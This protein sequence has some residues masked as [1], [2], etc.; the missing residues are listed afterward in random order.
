MYEM[1]LFWLIC[2]R[3][4]FA[5]NKTTAPDI[6]RISLEFG[7][8]VCRMEVPAKLLFDGAVPDIRK[9]QKALEIQKRT[10]RYSN[11][12]GE[13]ET[14][15]CAFVQLHKNSGGT[16]YFSLHIH[17]MLWY[18]LL[19]FSKGYRLVN[20]YSMLGLKSSASAAMYIVVGN[21]TKSITYDIDRLRKLL[22]CD[23]PG[24]NR[25][26]NFTKVLERAREELEQWCTT[27]F[28]YNARRIGKRIARIEIIPHS[29][30]PSRSI[31]DDV[32]NIANSISTGVDVGVMEYAR[33][34]FNL[35]PN[36]TKT[37]GAYLRHFKN[38]EEAMQLLSDI[39]HTM[40]KGHPEGISN[41]G[42]YLISALKQACNRLM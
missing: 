3:A 1:R 6:R 34:S 29:N 25:G 7:F 16:W 39:K 36:G 14:N 37:A 35:T 8:D 13:F 10:F 23:T 24:Y 41:P 11:E 21:Q 22:G 30:L 4:Q 19:N 18:M 33:E 28:D 5:A 32:K 38:R 26:N 42:G 9:A 40:H 2:L 17:Q 31:Y 20:L 15:V 12:Y 27:S